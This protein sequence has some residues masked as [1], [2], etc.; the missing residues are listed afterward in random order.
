MSRLIVNTVRP[1]TL[2]FVNLMDLGQNQNWINL[3]NERISGV[4]Y[5]NDTGRPILVNVS[6]TTNATS[7][8]TVD[9]QIVGQNSGINGDSTISIV[10]PPNSTYSCTGVIIFWA[11]LR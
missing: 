3:T 10:V 6:E 2:P 11:E 4:T 1:S 7:V 8:F 9:G 5:R